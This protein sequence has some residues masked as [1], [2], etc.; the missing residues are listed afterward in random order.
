MSIKGAIVSDVPD[1]RTL[2]LTVTLKLDKL[3][4]L[5]IDTIMIARKIL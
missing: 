1:R 4:L 5:V 2:N 3:N